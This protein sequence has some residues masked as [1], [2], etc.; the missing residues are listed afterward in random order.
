QH[1]IFELLW[2][3][4]VALVCVSIFG[5]ASQRLERWGTRR[6]QWI[7]P[8]VFGFVLLNIFMG[9][10]GNTALF[11]GFLGAGAG[12]QNLAQFHYKRILAKE[13]GSPARAV[14]VGSSQTRAQIDEELLNRLL[15]TNLWTTELHFPGCHAYDLLLIER[16]I[17][18]TRPDVIVC[19]LSEGY[20]YGG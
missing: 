18:P 11:W 7:F 3:M 14:L 15:G 8:A 9:F 1:R 6:T 17:R 20:F 5:W 10:A 13:S 4:T 2:L 16:Q 19:Y 12:T